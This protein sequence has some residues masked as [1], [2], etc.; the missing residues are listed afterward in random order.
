MICVAVYADYFREHG[1]SYDQLAAAAVQSLPSAPW[2]DARARLEVLSAVTAAVFAA[3]AFLLFLARKE[4]KGAKG[5]EEAPQTNG[6]SK[7]A[8]NE[9]SVD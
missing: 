6:H 9:K 4:P 5:P 3:D 8:Q 1:R 2:C 7:P